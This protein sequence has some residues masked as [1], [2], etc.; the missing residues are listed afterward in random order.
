MKRKCKQCGEDKPLDEYHWC[1]NCRDRSRSKL[2]RV[3][4]KPHAEPPITPFDRACREDRV[5]RAAIPT[6]SIF[7]EIL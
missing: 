6:T 5:R 2:R 1:Q 4:K 3:I 7:Q